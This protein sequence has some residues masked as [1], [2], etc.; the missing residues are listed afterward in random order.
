MVDEKQQQLICRTYTSID[1]SGKLWAAVMGIM[2]RE[3]GGVYHPRDILSNMGEDVLEVLKSKPHGCT[4]ST[5]ATGHHGVQSD[6]HG[7][8][9]LS[10]GSTSGYGHYHLPALAYTIQ[11]G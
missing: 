4:T 9:A 1:L 7:P 10:R 11:R 5:F 2:D 6:G 3:R 8:E